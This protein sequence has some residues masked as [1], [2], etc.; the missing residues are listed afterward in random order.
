MRIDELNPP[1]APPSARCSCSV[2]VVIPSLT[3]GSG[4]TSAQSNPHLSLLVSCAFC[5]LKSVFRLIKDQ[6]KFYFFDSVEV[7]GINKILYYYCHYSVYKNDIHFSNKI[8]SFYFNKKNTFYIIIIIIIND[9]VQ[10]KIF[11]INN[12]F[13]K[14]SQQIT[15]FLIYICILPL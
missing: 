7:T 15:C 2:F 5:F 10:K 4:G 3:A 14:K 13:L 1:P 9:F 12:F 6:Q 8:I 11:V